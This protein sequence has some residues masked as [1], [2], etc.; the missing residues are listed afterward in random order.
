MQFQY[1]TN[2]VLAFMA[3]YITHK[4]ADETA[5]K[6]VGVNSY[7][8]TLTIDKAW[9]KKLISAEDNNLSGENKYNLD[10]MVEQG[11]EYHFPKYKVMIIH[12]DLAGDCF[13]ICY[14]FTKKE[15]KKMTM[16]EIEEKLG[17]EI[18]LIEQKEI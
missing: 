1:T 4:L 5:D 11:L 12:F 13:N 10:C 17:Y 18:E 3:G 15:P 14:N 2:P 6:L 16:A 9:F 8:Q 7:K